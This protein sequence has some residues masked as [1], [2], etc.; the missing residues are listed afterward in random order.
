MGV[1]G[2]GRRP[3]SPDKRDFKMSDA[4]NVLEK[5]TPPR[6]VKTWHSDRVLNQGETPHCVGF[7]WAGWGIAMPVEDPWNNPMGHNIYAACK[8]LDG[9]PG[10]Q[11]GSSVRTGAKVMMQ[12]G[13]IGTYFFA[14]SVDEAAN[15]VARYGPVVLGTDWYTGMSYPSTFGGVI[16]PTGKIEG[17]HAYLWLGVDSNYAIIRNSWGVGWGKSGDA[18]ILL[19]DL[20]R[21]FAHDG[22][23]CAATEK[24]LRGVGVHG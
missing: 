1:H 20:K 9:E 12:R 7:S 22:E 6:P 23:A 4:V 14:S 24:V 11:N 21:V 15:Y 17:G 13:K 8:I 3:S 10:E 18:K 19:T 5:L 16:K 2:L